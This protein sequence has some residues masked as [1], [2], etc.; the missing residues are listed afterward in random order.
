MRRLVLR[1]APV[2]GLL[3]VGAVVVDCGSDAVGSDACRT[4]EPKRCELARSC[5]ELGIDSDEDVRTC[6]TFYRDQC[7]Y[8]VSNDATEPGD[9]ETTLCIEALEQAAACGS[10]NLADC[11][12]AP[13]Y[14]PDEVVANVTVN[15]GCALVRHPEGLDGCSFLRQEPTAPAE[16]GTDASG[17]AGGEGGA[18]AGAGGT[19][20]AGGAGS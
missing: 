5:P 18:A 2:F 16:G 12:N 15:T 7:L 8:G 13:G 3:L 4:I 20:G 11:A 14:D 6:E 1:L 9:A 17:G 19:G 10:T